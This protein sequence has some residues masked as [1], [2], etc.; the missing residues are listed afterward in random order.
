M[1][2]FM[3]VCACLCVVL[4]GAFEPTPPVIVGPP[5]QIYKA[6]GSEVN[7]TCI[8]TGVPQPTITWYKDDVLLPNQVAPLLLIQD[9]S[10]D[11]RGLYM[12]VATNRLGSWNETVYVKINGTF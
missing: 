5:Q 7:L 4:A 10:L 1:P 6:I 11:T 2:R 8:A 3:R 9:L 12:C